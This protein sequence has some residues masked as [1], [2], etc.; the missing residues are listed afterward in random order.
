MKK[1][2]SR[3]NIDEKTGKASANVDCEQS[4]AKEEENNI[5]EL[6]A[7][8]FIKLQPCNSLPE[9]QSQQQASSSDPSS[10]SSSNNQ[11]PSPESLHGQH[12][13]LAVE[14][15]DDEGMNQIDDCDGG[16]ASAKKK[17]KMNIASNGS[18]STSSSNN[19]E[20]VNGGTL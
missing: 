7:Q 6:M 8:K 11:I 4:A 5:D 9:L 19:L 12:V 14:A 13:I 10:S 18:S 15:E 17:I 20:Y 1:V 3:V 16:A 2:N